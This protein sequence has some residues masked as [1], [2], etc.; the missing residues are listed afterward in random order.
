MDIEVGEEIQLGDTLEAL[1]QMRLYL[2]RVLALRQNLQ[3]FIVG[4]K[5]EPGREETGLG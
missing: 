1:L 3:H 4:Q 2:Q 5:E